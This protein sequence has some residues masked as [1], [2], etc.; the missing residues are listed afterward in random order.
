MGLAV[1]CL[2]TLPTIPNLQYLMRHG[3]LLIDKPSGK[4]SHDV[5]QK[6]RHALHEPKI[7]HLGTL[8]PAATGLL[9]LFVGKKALKTVELFEGSDKEYE[10]AI[11]LG[12]ISSTYDGEGVIE[13]V[14]EKSGWAAPNEVKLLDI[15]KTSFIG[16]IK[17][18]PPAHSA[19]HVHGKRAYEIIRKNPQADL[20]MPERE[21]EISNMQLI[22]Y[23]YPN[24]KLR[25]ACSSGTYIRS[26]AH[27][28]GKLLRCGG[29][30]EKLRRTRVGSW[31]LDYAHKLEDVT[32]GQII[33]LKEILTVFPRVDIDEKQWKDVQH[34][35]LID[36]QINDELSI[37]WHE[38]LPV[39]I[40]EKK[41]DGAHPRK[42]F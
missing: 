42:V 38:D 15:L 9:V 36:V 29:Y 39:A 11:H 31:S 13:D 23:G 17:Q 7:G 32:W 25:I 26:I 30:L 12:K 24:V 19:V 22:S 3:I 37:A 4:T 14:P 21:V 33:P 34:G 40:F 5:V 41:S 28:L 20:D 18:R 27:D 16:T 10:A 8:D 1:F 2:L 6:V 35:K